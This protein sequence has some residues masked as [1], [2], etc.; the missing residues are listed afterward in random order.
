MGTVQWASQVALV[1]KN[2]PANA[3]DPRDEGLIPVWG[4]SPGGGHGNPLQYSC[5][6]N[7]MDR[8][9]WWATFHG[10]A[11]SQTQR[12]TYT[13]KKVNRMSRLGAGHHA[14]SE[15]GRIP[16]EYFWVLMFMHFSVM[17]ASLKSTGFC[18]DSPSTV[19]LKSFSANFLSQAVPQ[20]VLV[21]FIFL[22][23]RHILHSP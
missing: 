12:S 6:E 20:F 15:F 9:A 3:G 4:R 5:L 1:V 10:A 19:T 16:R 22:R 8:E 11:K 17:L 7:P 18:L 21:W 13:Q 23:S 14:E 2:L